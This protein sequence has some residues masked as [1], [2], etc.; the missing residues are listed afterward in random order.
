MLKGHLR[1]LARIMKGVDE[2]AGILSPR[3]DPCRA[4]ISIKADDR[5]SECAC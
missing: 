5:F 3:P 4:V 2:E 1:F